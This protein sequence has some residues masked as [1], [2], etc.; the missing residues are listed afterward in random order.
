[1]GAGT[2]IEQGSRS[3]SECRV[4]ALHRNHVPRLFHVYVM[5]DCRGKRILGL[6][7]PV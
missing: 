1:M 4:P 6:G 3:Q 2:R 5:P 7:S